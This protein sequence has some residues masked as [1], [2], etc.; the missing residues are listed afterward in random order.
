MKVRHLHDW[1]I[2]PAEARRIQTT[3][4]RQVSQVNEIKKACLVAGVDI[5]VPKYSA[6]ARAAIVA[7]TYPGF[8]VVETQIAEGEL[9]FPYIPGLLSFR[10]APLIL[11]ACQKL[12]TNPNL[13]MVDGQGISHPRH[14]GLAS[15]LGLL[16]NTPTIG[17][18]K[19]RLCGS[20]DPPPY[21]AGT[22]SEL[23]DNDNIIGAVLRTKRGTKPIYVSIGHKIDL[24]TA[25]YWTM[26]C[27]RGY[28]L[29]E[30]TRLAHLIAGGKHFTSA[31]ITSRR[32]TGS[33]L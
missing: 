14:F 26:E 5:S 25:I 28:R 10:E 33:P 20:H 9:F 27:C 1:Q 3:L 24:P 7:M 15:H 30:L 21:E 31:Q 32:N 16:L 2:T 11:T 19:S 23:T 12:S 8:E 4:A 18:A 13:I 29:P 22:Y 17:C 6:L